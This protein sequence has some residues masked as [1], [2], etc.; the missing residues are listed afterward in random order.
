MN[1][2]EVQFSLRGQTLPADHGYALYSALKKYLQSLDSEQQKEFLIERNLP[3]DLLICSIAGIPNQNGIIY[4]NQNARFRLRCPAENA[5]QWYRILQNQVL[6]IRGHLIRFIQP[7]LTLPQASEILK[8]RLVTFRLDNWNSNEAPVY[9]L[10]SCQK[11]L[12]KLDINAQVYIDSNDQGNLAQ[13]A[14]KIHGKNV[15][16]YGVTVEGLNPEDSLKLQGMGLGG[17]KHF[18][19]GW[20]YPVQE[21]DHG[22]EIRA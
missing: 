9:F 14:I 4:L 3:P 13:R 2:L 16:G 22:N 19:C 1:F 11:R 6:D 7:R 15:L 5:A 10:E 18:G 20:F 21:V 12:A 8:A 17:R